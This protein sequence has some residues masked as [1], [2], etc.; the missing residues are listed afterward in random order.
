M[1]MSKMLYL[2]EVLSS[3]WADI[4][5]VTDIPG[6]CRE[7]LCCECCS[8]SSWRKRTDLSS[9]LRA[10]TRSCAPVALHWVS[11]E[12]LVLIAIDSNVLDKI[13][14]YIHGDI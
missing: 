2:Q 5:I 13:E 3:G 10:P 11:S 9:C 12:R 8:Y 7:C 1:A 14:S 6:R 4:V